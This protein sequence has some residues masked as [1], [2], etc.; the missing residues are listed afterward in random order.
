[1]ELLKR[2]LRV[3][4]TFLQLLITAGDIYPLHRFAG[5]ARESLIKPAIL[6]TARAGAIVEHAK[7]LAWCSHRYPPCLPRIH[8]TTRSGTAWL[9]S[10]LRSSYITRAT[11]YHRPEIPGAF[12]S[13][14]G[15]HAFRS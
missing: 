9:P 15:S 7:L 8:L 12:R 3:Y 6:D 13:L 1:M 5:P 2:G 4:T 11:L 14:F 10:T